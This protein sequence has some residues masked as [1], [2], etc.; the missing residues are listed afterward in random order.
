MHAINTYDT[1]QQGPGE[2]T[3]AYLH[4][5][6]DIWEHIHHSNNMSEITAIGPNH[7]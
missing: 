1:L 7:T 3:E 6:Q 2:P 5:T 4:S